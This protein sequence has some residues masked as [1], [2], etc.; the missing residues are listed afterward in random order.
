MNQMDY[1]AGTVE[2]LTK[3]VAQ[4]E[5]ALRKEMQR[6][7]SLADRKA[8]RGKNQ[9]ADELWEKADEIKKILD[10]HIMDARPL[11]S[12]PGTTSC[13]SNR[14]DG[15]RGLGSQHTSSAEPK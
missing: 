11:A 8:K 2:V 13:E 6:Y 7:I 3:R 10:S 12:D 9:A 5:T 4:L 1:L 14:Q 15:E